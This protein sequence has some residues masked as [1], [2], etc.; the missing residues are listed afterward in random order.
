MSVQTDDNRRITTPGREIKNTF[1][2]QRYINYRVFQLWVG[3]G[4]GIKSVA[5][6]GSLL[7]TAENLTNLWRARICPSDTERRCNSLLLTF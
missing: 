6:V 7:G 4:S 5:E 2:Q 1:A 3:S